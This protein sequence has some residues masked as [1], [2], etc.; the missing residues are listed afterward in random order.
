MADVSGLT[1]SGPTVYEIFADYD[2]MVNPYPLYR[3]ILAE[4]PVDSTGG[5]LVLTRYADV[6]AALRH[7]GLSSDDRHD[8]VQRERAASGTLSPQ[9]LAMTERRSFLHR[10]PPTHTQLRNVAAS[11]LGL[12]SVD[13]LAPFVEQF[14]NEAIDKADPQRTMEFIGELAYPL[15]L[16]VTSRM[17]G[18]D[19]AEHTP[20]PWWRSQLCADFEAPA[21]AGGDC[22]EYSD[23]VQGKMEAYFDAVLTARRQKPGDDVISALLAAHDQGL[24]TLAE[25]ND[26]CRLLLVAGHETTTGLLANGMLALLR[27]PDQFNLLRE[28]PELAAQA[29]D[30]VL[31]YDTAVQFTR[32][33]AIH[34]LQVN[35]IDVTAGQMVLLWLGAAHRDPARFNEPDR[36]DITRTGPAHLGF[37]AG[38]H[39]C[40]ATQIA[41]LTGSITFATVARR[42]VEPALTSD[43]PPYLPNAVRAIESLPIQFRDV[44][45]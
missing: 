5:P 12:V 42:L 43:P 36:F 13:A 41:R 9:L 22:A 11:A 44:A 8:A 31:R 15:P 28:R 37:G 40:M 1:D 29:V 4:R 10:D 16:A 33:V 27:N 14:V 25:V 32:R 23:S 17:L 3:R 30:E 18:L 7:P 39:A 45:A 38:P 21:V 20:A 35:G 19:P 6:E 26:T 24:L 2:T 34:D